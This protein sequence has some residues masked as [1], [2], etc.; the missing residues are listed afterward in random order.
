MDGKS[1]KRKFLVTASALAATIIGSQLGYQEAFAKAVA[2]ESGLQASSHADFVI[3][4]PSPSDG[5]TLG[6]SSHQSHSSHSSHASHYSSS[7]PSP[8]PPPDP[9]DS[10]PSHGSHSSHSSHASHHSHYSGS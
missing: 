3:Q 10:P 8:P 5:A 1:P 7:S 2:T 6:H 9:G 4:P